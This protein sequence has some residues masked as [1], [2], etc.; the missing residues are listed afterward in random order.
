MEGI[1]QTRPQLCVALFAIR[2][3]M[4]STEGLL[5]VKKSIVI[6]ICS[7]SHLTLY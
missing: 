5:V 4:Q 7:T 6:K 1:Y 3:N 2:C